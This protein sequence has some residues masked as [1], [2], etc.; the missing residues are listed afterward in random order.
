LQHLSTLYSNPSELDQGHLIEWNSA[1]YDINRVSLDEIIPGQLG[2]IVLISDV[3]QRLN[4]I[5]RSLHEGM[6]ATLGSLV[7]AE[8]ILLCLIRVPLRRLGKL[9]NTLPL[10]AEAPMIKLE[11]VFPHSGKKRVS[12]MKLIICTTVPSPYRISL[13]KMRL[14]WR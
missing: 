3:S 1:H 8:F 10:L 9:A 6:L 11:I 14:P 7:A 13:R 5:E 2:F 12:A 4:T